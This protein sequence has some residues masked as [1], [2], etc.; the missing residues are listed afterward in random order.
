MASRKNFNGNIVELKTTILFD[1]WNKIFRQFA[2]QKF[3]VCL[4]KQNRRKNESSFIF[5]INSR[6]NSIKLPVLFIIVLKKKHIRF[7]KKCYSL[8]SSIYF[9]RE[10]C[11]TNL[12]KFLASKILQNSL[13]CIS[14]LKLQ[15]IYF[16]C[17]N[18]S[19]NWIAWISLIWNGWSDRKRL[20]TNKCFAP[21]FFNFQS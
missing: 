1:W 20:T 10:N 9:S 3:D 15:V 19:I 18:V 4:E 6:N 5:F 8:I 2:Y 16:A 11:P 12:T 21:K 7:D 13:F 17:S 14:P